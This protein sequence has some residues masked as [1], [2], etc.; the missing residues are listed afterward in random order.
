MSG[1]TNFGVFGPTNNV[2]HFG[3]QFYFGIVD[4][5]VFRV[6]VDGAQCIVSIKN[7][8]MSQNV[9][10]KNIETTLKTDKEFFN[11]LTESFL[12]SPINVTEAN[13]VVSGSVIYGGK[14]GAA[15]F[16]QDNG[17]DHTL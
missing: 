10:I 7:G 8:K 2:S 13:L 11:I 3:T 14:I 9:E 15:A 6:R 4:S 5:S 1:A 17:F 16:A 12:K